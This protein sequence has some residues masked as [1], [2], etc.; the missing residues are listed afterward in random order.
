MEFDAK[1]EYSISVEALRLWKLL[2]FL[3]ICHSSSPS[4]KDAFYHKLGP[5]EMA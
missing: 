2:Y 4:F 1:T 3:C 5:L